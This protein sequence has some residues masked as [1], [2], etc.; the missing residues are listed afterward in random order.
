MLQHILGPHLVPEC[1]FRAPEAVQIPKSGEGL[2][3]FEPRL[4]GGNPR[5]K[6]PVCTF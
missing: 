3:P 1:H 6:S 5:L 4:K 2:H